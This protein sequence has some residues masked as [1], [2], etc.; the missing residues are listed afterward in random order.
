MKTYPLEGDA[1]YILETARLYDT[2]TRLFMTRG[3]KRFGQK[4]VALVVKT[5]GEQMAALTLA[6]LR[7]VWLLASQ[8]QL[9]EAGGFTVMRPGQAPFDGLLYAPVHSIETILREAGL[10]EGDVLFAVPIRGAEV[11]MAKRAGPARVLARIGAATRCFPFPPWL[12]LQRLPVITRED[13]ESTRMG[14]AY[15]PPVALPGVRVESIA[16]RIVITMPKAVA[17]EVATAMMSQDM[18]AI[19]STH[20]GVG[21]AAAFVFSPGEQTPVAITADP[22]VPHDATK[23]FAGSTA[24]AFLT[25][26]K[27]PER[28]VTL[29]EDGFF[30]TLPDRE[31]SQ[32]RSG[33]RVGRDLNLAA[34]AN[35]VELNVRLT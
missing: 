29:I 7:T 20:M 8:G 4:E 23:P 9:I 25:L 19:A 34:T 16:D 12:D 14:T 3:L 26:V 10:E 17:R 33:L 24:A 28:H 6:F 15:P 13:L 30:F 31:W 2:D 18:V 35:S 11:E 22:S 27:D 32:L 21:S 5:A 1:E